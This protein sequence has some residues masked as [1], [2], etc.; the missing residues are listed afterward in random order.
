VPGGQQAQQVFRPRGQPGNRV[1]APFGIEVG[2][3]QV[4]TQQREDG[5]VCGTS[6]A[7]RAARGP[8]VR[9]GASGRQSMRQ[10]SNPSGRS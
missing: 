6:T 2:L 10:C 4:R 3:V 1:A 8:A 5:P 7:A 9:P